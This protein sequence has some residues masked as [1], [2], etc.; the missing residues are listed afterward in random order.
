ME[1]ER[2]MVVFSGYRFSVRNDAKKK[3]KMANF[4][5]YAFYQNKTMMKNHKDCY[6]WNE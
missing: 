2:S 3:V 1:T 6:E 5:L 4:M